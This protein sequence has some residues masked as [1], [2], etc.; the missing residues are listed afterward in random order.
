MIY[1]TTTSSP[2][3]VNRKLWMSRFYPSIY[4]NNKKI[5]QVD[6][7]GNGGCNFYTFNTPE[8]RHA[9]YTF[10][11]G[12]YPKTVI[13]RDDHFIEYLMERDGLNG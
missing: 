7:D 2:V 13:E 4:Y 12:I 6:N 9:Y 10:V 3:C 5:G 11:E 1:N 8:L